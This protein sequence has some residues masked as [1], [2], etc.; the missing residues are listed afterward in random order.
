M[1]ILVF[2]KTV[3]RKREKNNKKKKAKKLMKSLK[4]K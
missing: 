3:S 1:S 4:R 2:K